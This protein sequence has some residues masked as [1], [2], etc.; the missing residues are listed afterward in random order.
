MSRAG[1]AYTFIQPDEADRAQDGSGLRF[2]SSHLRQLS[3]CRTLWMRCD[4]AIKRYR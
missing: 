3:P 4:S 1:F 2:E